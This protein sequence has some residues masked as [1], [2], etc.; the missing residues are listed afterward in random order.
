MTMLPG[1][2]QDAP[3]SP[4]ESLAPL[5]IPPPGNI[6]GSFGVSPASL[7]PLVASY[8]PYPS[9]NRASPYPSPIRAASPLIRVGTPYSTQGSTP[10]LEALRHMFPTTR[11]S[12]ISAVANHTFEAHDLYKLDSDA[13]RRNGRTLFDL[14]GRGTTIQGEG[15]ADYPTP[16]AL[17]DPLATYFR[18]LVAATAQADAGAALALADAGF[19]YV[20]HVVALA[21]RYEWA[22]VLA[23][24]FDFHRTR[25]LEMRRG[26]LPGRWADVDVG[27]LARHLVGKELAVSPRAGR[28]RT[29]GEP[30]PVVCQLGAAPVGGGVEG[31]DSSGAEGAHASEGG[32]ETEGGTDGVSLA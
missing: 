32:A 21:G 9:P 30:A 26:E 20:A 6:P 7:S 28:A 4:V 11:G 19:A 5:P 12:Y 24:H 14:Y 31:V 22:A 25:A 17:L 15:P 18:I 16:E 10:S 27:L 1:D 8:S 29:R 23:Y 3:P 13:A 2:Y